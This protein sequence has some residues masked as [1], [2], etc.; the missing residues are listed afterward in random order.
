MGLGFH[1]HFRWF[2]CS[3]DVGEEKPHP[4]IFEEAYRQAE[5]WMPGI[6]RHEILHI[7]DSLE[8]DFCGARAAGFQAV[9]LDRSESKVKVTKYQDWLQAPDYPGKSDEDIERWTV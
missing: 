8:S 6:Q 7:G 4:K 3:Q 5:F 9:H 2:T 1:E